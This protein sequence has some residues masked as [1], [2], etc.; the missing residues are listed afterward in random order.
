MSIVN[1]KLIAILLVVALVVAAFNIRIKN[2]SFE[3]NE[4]VSDTE[5][6]KVLF[7]KG[8]DGLSAVLF[9]KN[10]FLKKKNIP[11]VNSYTIEWVSPISI[12]IHVNEK[13]V[14]AFVRRD[15]NNLYFDAEGI[16][17]EVSNSRRD[18]AVEVTGIDFKNHN[19]GEK[20]EFDD[21]KLLNA[22]L[23]ISSF[24]K[25]NSLNASLIE[26]RKGSDIY[27]Y[28]G[29]IIVFMG[30]TKNME[31]KLQRLLDIYPQI[32]DLSGT[33]DLKD[34]KENMID[35]QYIFKKN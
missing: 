13:S 31:V 26:I 18:G 28:I 25:E 6:A 29:S 34:A 8:Y 22:I 23:N 15:I 20:I 35:E 30:D 17:N 9:L 33:L 5:V 19:V 10:K 24:L 11:L 16:I 27:I 2:I 14:V 3:G 7:E 32:K 1:R 4:R 21:E 12:I